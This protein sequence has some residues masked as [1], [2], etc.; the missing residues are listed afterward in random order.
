MAST[1]IGSDV[2]VERTTVDV[3]E[4]SGAGGEFAIVTVRTSVNRDDGQQLITED[5]QFAYRPESAQGAGSQPVTPLAMPV[6][7]GP[8]LTR[9]DDAWEVRP[10]PVVLARFS[11]LTANGHR[12]HY[13]VPYVT[14]VEGYPN[15]LVH[16]PLMATVLAE[17]ARRTHPD[18]ALRSFSCRARRP[19][20]LGG[21]GVVHVSEPGDPNL[22]LSLVEA[23]GSD[24]GPFM[25]ASVTYA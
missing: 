24:A 6:T 7:Q 19:F 23:I 9:G 5:T 18:R 15:L 3:T 10:N 14:Q 4:K 20:F 11:A 8:W 22:D 1:P 17:V 16:G 25:T 13:D 12:I 21:V 2:V